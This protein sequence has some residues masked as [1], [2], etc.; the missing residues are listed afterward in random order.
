MK[1]HIL[2][3][4][5]AVLA[6]AAALAAGRILPFQ[7]LAS[8]KAGQTAKYKLEILDGGGKVASTTEKVYKLDSVEDGDIVMGRADLRVEA[9]A[10]EIIDA[11]RILPRG[12]PA[13]GLAAKPEK[14]GKVRVTLE[15]TLQDG[16]TTV[17]LDALFEP[18]AGMLGVR[19]ARVKIVG[20]GAGESV[21]ELVE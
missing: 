9:D 13:K 11:M 21:Y 20:G 3:A 10:P 12:T 14:D 15:S 8:A 6:G 1:Q 4:A 19:R 18:K 7:P 5:V 16:Q 2:L 17:A